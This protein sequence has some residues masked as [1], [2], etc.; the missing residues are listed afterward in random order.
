MLNCGTRHAHALET[1]KTFVEQV[2]KSERTPLLTCLL[3]G[4]SGSGKTALAASIGID[5]GFPFIKI[6]SAENMIGLQ[7][8]TKC[9]M[10]SKVTSTTFKSEMRNFC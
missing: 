10:I 9:A 3:E 8:S 4:P 2:K 5:S 6:V 7:E 1:V